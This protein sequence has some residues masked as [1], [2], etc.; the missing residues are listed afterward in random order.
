MV[1]S[2]NLSTTE[3]FTIFVTKNKELANKTLSTSLILQMLYEL[4]VAQN[5]SK[6][7]LQRKKCLIT[8]FY[9]PKY[10]IHRYLYGIRLSTVN[11]PNK[12]L[13][14]ILIVIECSLYGKK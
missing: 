4:L 13:N 6:N 14:L 2:T 9:R 5:F 3:S 11:L 8:F 10:H 12:K 1:S 7:M